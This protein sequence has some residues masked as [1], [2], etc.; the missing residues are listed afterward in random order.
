MGG[1]EALSGVIGFPLGHSLSPFIHHYWIDY[2]NLSAKYN[3]VEIPTENFRDS[4][5]K[6]IDE[7][8]RGFNVTLPYKQK[9]MTLCE[10]LDETAQCIGAVNTI[11]I[12]DRGA[13]HGMNTDSFGFA[14]NIKDSGISLQNKTALVLGAGGA[15][16]AV[17]HG[18]LSLGIQEIKIANRT[19]EK[20]VDISRQFPVTVI[21]WDRREKESAAIDLLVNT[22]SLGMNGQ[23]ALDFDLEYLPLSA[24]IC[25]IVYKPLHT[26][27]LRHAAA[28]G[29]K[30]ITGTGMLL[31]QARPAFYTWFGVMPEITDELETGLAEK[32]EV[33]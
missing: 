11:K 3:A 31:H 27:L 23:S 19:R 26:D 5:Q 1:K 16:R 24:T 21:D 25:D 9:I 17:I 32:A 6:L 12:D 28:R 7:S 14:E 33:Q 18:L 4:V 22:T 8:Y 30:V 20:A 15:A 2:Y 29:H 10:S 13:L